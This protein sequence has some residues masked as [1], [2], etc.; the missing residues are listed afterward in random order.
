M[1]RDIR[2]ER[3]IIIV[4]LFFS[5]AMLVMG[6]YFF[7][8]YYQTDSMIDLVIAAILVFVCSYA[9]IVYLRKI[10]QQRFYGKIEKLIEKKKLRTVD[11]IQD[12]VKKSEDKIFQAIEYLRE[13]GY[14]D[15]YVLSG[16]VI[17]N[18]KEE[19]ER[20]RRYEE[21]KKKITLQWLESQKEILDN[22]REIVADLNKE[23]SELCE[24]CGAVVK[25]KG[26]RGS[27]PYCGSPVKRK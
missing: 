27:C 12:V 24:S 9:T 26:E 6:G 7:I 17:L 21:E 14:L 4:L 20:R 18:V 22:Q 15:E 3:T 11:E 8:R 16:R 10:K 1:D 5:L 13:N 2:S 19:K 25:F 23:V